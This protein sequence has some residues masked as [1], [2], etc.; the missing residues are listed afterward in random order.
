MFSELK[1]NTFF[2]DY[3]KC[4][5]E[6]EICQINLEQS[7]IDFC[8]NNDIN[9]T[10]FKVENIREDLVCLLLKAFFKEKSSILINNRLP[11]FSMESCSKFRKLV[12]TKN[13]IDEILK[14]TTS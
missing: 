8:Q 1:K 9:F 5:S 14:I 10:S 12:N 6:E 3:N 2:Q 7:F 11:Y 13:K 4:T